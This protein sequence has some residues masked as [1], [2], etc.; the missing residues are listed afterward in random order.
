VRGCLRRNW[1]LLFERLDLDQSGRLGYDEM[2]SAV[3]RELDVDIPD[4]ELRAFWTY[5]D[6]DASGEVTI[7]E[8]QH[9]CYLLLV[10]GWPD[11][12]PE[13]VARVCKALQ[14]AATKWFRVAE[15]NW[16]KLPAAARKAPRR[17]SRDSLLSS[18]TLTRAGEPPTRQVHA[19]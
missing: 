9:G 1:K 18:Q 14:A 15:G 2:E 19:L 13:A 4:E 17:A 8:F 12:A 5:I 6:H 7:G 11:L 16:F 10:E 3:R